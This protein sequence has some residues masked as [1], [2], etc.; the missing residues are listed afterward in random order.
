MF[1]LTFSTRHS[2]GRSLLILFI[3]SLLHVQTTVRPFILVYR[4]STI[5]LSCLDCVL[6]SAARLIGKIPTYDHVTRNWRKLVQN[7]GGRPKYWG[8]GARW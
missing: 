6:R 7:I 4:L 1:V 3:S 5:R 2:T 8:K